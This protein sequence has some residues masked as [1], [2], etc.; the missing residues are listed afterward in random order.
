MTNLSD[1]PN[2]WAE[3]LNPLHFK[4]N[5]PLVELDWP[6]TTNNVRFFAK[7]EFGG[8][9]GSHKDR[10]YA[11]MVD[12]LERRGDIRPGQRLI[13]F[14]SG[15]GGAALSFVGS[16]KGYPVTIVRPSG[17]SVVK[18]HQIRSLGANL[19]ITPAAE[20]VEGARRVASEL[21]DELGK[22]AYLVHQTDSLLNIEAFEECGREIVREM[23]S[24]GL[25]IHGFVCGIGTGGTLSGVAKVIKETFPNVF[26]IG[27]EVEGADLNLAR[28]EQRQ[29]TMRPHHL[30]GLSPGMI[31][32]NTHLQ[33]VNELETCS[34]GESWNATFQ[35]ERH[36]FLVGP[37]SGL[38]ISIG[39]RLAERLP[40]GSNLVTIFFDAA[41]KYYP[42]R[43]NWLRSLNVH[44]NGDDLPHDFLLERSCS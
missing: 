25:A 38:N 1:S 24:Q 20:G 2:T 13:D 19:R 11:F 17:L 30:E 6:E 37:S 29:I 41:W 43:D 42:E 27:G 35:L 31:F 23:L 5:T 4:R 44:D 39:R 36:G 32:A 14:S 21:A 3:S 7:C 8:P 40:N 26:V 22:E 16:V 12:A 18:A 28:L 15:N 33:F 34:E 9:T 10:M